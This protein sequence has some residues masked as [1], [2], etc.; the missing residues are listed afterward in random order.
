[1]PV[2]ILNDAELAERLGVTRG[3][4]G[5]WARQHVIPSI[6]DGRNRRLFILDSVLKAIRKRE[7]VR[8]AR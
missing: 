2:I 4:V 6:R 1:M 3:T 7:E 5:S 8:R